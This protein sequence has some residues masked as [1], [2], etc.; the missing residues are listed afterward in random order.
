[1]R[2]RE[3][4]SVYYQRIFCFAYAVDER[5][6]ICYCIGIGER[7]IAAVRVEAQRR[8]R[9]VVRYLVERGV[10]FVARGRPAVVD[11]AVRRRVKINRL[12]CLVR[13]RQRRFREIRLAVHR[14]KII[15]RDCQLVFRVRRTVKPQ[16]RA[17]RLI[18]RR[19]YAV[20]FFYRDDV[21]VAE[22]EHRARRDVA[23]Y[24]AAV[25]EH[26]I[27]LQREL[28]VIGPVIRQCA[29]DTAEA[30]HTR[31]DSVIRPKTR[32]F[33]NQSER[34]NGAVTL[35]CAQSAIS[36]VNIAVCGF[37]ARAV[38]QIEAFAARQRHDA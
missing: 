11:C 25:V 32:R 22:A 36:N 20:G 24:R 2:I 17:R 15:A 1:M 5:E 16:R 33:S 6:S 35:R 38:C 18:R 4:R 3:G 31:A 14:H 34:R 19:E 28:V 7:D 27:A 10:D 8:R 12:A 13:A 26:D 37:Q 9:P 21:A 23:R 29:L 30:R